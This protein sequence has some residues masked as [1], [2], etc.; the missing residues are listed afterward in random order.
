M[1]V[2]VR[3]DPRRQRLF[4]DLHHRGRRRK[5]YTGLLDTRAN[6]EMLVAKAETIER[7]VFLGIFDIE[8]HFPE[9]RTRPVTF[10]ELYAEWT[11]KK[12]NEVSALTLAHY[13]EMIERKV[14]PCWGPRRLDAFTPSLF[15]RFKAALLEQKLAPR[16]VNIVLTRLREL[17]RLAYERGYT[18]DDL[19]RWVVFV[20]DIRPDIHPLSFEEKESF[21]AALPV[22]WRPYF[23]VAFGTG[24][25]PSEQLALGWP[26]IDWE[27]NVIE[28]REGWRAGQRTRLKTAAS[29][30]DVDMLRPV[31]KAL[32]AQRLIA[33]GSPLVFPNRL[34]GH[35]NL[36]NLRRRVWYATLVKAGLRRRDL[37]NTRHTFATHALAS[38]EDPGWVAKML[39]HTTLTM[40]MTRYY[41]YVPNLV[42]RDG[43]RLAQQLERRRTPSAKRPLPPKATSP[44]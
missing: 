7:E 33:G 36:N 1:G 8:R 3:L 42:R 29:N 44:Q 4:L 9:A 24:L 39:G 13:Q 2:K 15:D 38:G 23:E 11:R 27:R 5:I 40:L 34:G 26:R 21:L 6:R 43:V 18:K 16:T 12:A 10:R 28:V 37:Y 14:L 20:R 19:A 32:E 31:R 35:I 17:L 30:R 25:R 41:R 22:R